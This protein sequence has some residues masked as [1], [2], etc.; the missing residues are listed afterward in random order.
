MSRT[1]PDFEELVKLANE[2]PEELELI[3]QKDRFSGYR[4]YVYLLGQSTAFK[5]NDPEWLFIVAAYL[6]NLEFKSIFIVEDQTLKI[7]STF[8]LPALILRF[9][10]NNAEKIQLGYIH[11]FHNIGQENID[12]LLTDLPT[13][14]IV[15]ERN[16]TPV[17]R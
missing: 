7:K 11:E 4:Y 6:L 17:W 15:A 5:I 9:L 3:R 10:Y 1:L 16:K 2:N 12:E 14:F 13:K 8:R